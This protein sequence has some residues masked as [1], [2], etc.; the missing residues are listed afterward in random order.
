[1]RKR[2]NRI[3]G[4]TEKLVIMGFVLFPILFLFL[5]QHI[6]EQTLSYKNTYNEQGKRVYVPRPDPKPKKSFGEII[7]L[8]RVRHHSRSSRVKSNLKCLGT[9]VA[10][11]FACG[12]YDVY[13]DPIIWS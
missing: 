4:S 2:E 7:G 13:P 12:T 3:L 6:S 5:N 9:G 11:Y 8:Y 1:M 10:T